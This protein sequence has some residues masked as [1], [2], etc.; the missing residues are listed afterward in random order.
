VDDKLQ[1]LPID[2][3]IKLVE[4][5]WDSIAVEQKALPL[6]STQKSELDRR[7]NAYAIDKNRGRLASDAVSSIRR[8]L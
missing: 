5:I 6:T 2:E 3:R 7:L 4:D 1:E 8:R